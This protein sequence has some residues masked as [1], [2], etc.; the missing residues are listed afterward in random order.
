MKSTHD[1]AWQ[2]SDQQRDH[3][4]RDEPTPIQGNAG[5][6]G[7]GGKPEQQRAIQAKTCRVALHP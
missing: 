5:D 2:N 4:G 7:H 3:S 6:Q 1:R